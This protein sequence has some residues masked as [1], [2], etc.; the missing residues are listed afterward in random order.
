MYLVEF[1][2]FW[3]VHYTLFVSIEEYYEIAY[4][5]PKKGLK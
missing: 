3:D 5:I 1:V 4:G 2:S